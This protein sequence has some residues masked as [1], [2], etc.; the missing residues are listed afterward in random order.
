MA[1]EIINKDLGK[2]I[3]S[4]PSDPEL[5]P[6]QAAQDSLG[7]ISTDGQIE[8]CKGRLL[9][10][11]EETANGFVKGDVWGYRADGTQIHFRKVNT[12]IQYYNTTTDLWV[13]IVTGLTSSAEYSLSPYISTAGTFIY[14]TGIDGIYKI[15]T[16]NLGSYNTMYGPTDVYRGKSI[17]STGRMFMW[18]LP[19]SKSSLYGS[20][21]DGMELVTGNYTSV[22][23]EATTS[24]SGTLAFKAGD[25]KRNCFVVVITLTVSG[26]IYR[27]NLNGG[28]IGSL[29]GTGTI[30][31]I[32][33]AYTISAAGVGTASYQ[34][35]MSNSKGVTDFS[36]SATRLPLEGFILNQSEGGDFIQTVKAYDNKFYSIKNRTV[37]ELTI[38]AT[39]TTFN[40]T[41]FRRNIGL[42]YWRASVST[43]K[44]V[45]FMDTSNPE[46]PKLTI[47]QK[48]ITGDNLEPVTLADHFDFSVY[49]W[50][51]CAMNTFGEFIVFSGHTPASD[52]NNKLFFYNVRRNTV[53]ILGYEAKTIT[54]SDGLLYI[55]DTTTDNVYE[56]LSG[57]DDDNDTIE[58]YWISNDERYDTE[59]LKKVKKL[60]LKG[61]ITHDQTLQVYVSYDNNGYELV[62]TIRGDGSYVDQTESFSIGGHGIGTAIIGGEATTLLGNFYF[63]ELK[64][65]STKFRKRSIKLIASGVGYVSVTMIDDFNIR[66]F[67]QRLPSKYRSKQNVS[68]DGSQTNIGVPYVTDAYVWYNTGVLLTFDQDMTGNPFVGWNLYINGVLQALHGIS[69]WGTPTELFLI[70]FGVN[71][72][73]DDTV[74]VT[75]DEVTGDTAGTLSDLPSITLI[76]P[77]NP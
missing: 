59:A 61:L 37:Y 6:Q 12:K 29:G 24:L 4:L 7:F 45:I 39:D 31:Y 74:L 53:D 16:A 15:H 20:H 57:F 8:L 47:L 48:N 68:L 75:Y 69:S 1:K 55:G 49:E 56:I 44:G 60:R 38:D 42:D 54:S 13:D 66:R 58:N 32:T 34:W 23:G 62:G 73:I 14:A 26:E 72:T 22:T 18:D 21:K 41:V 43:G 64:V 11:A 10:G 33:G 25:A 30:N 50:D 35:E 67:E 77:R 71:I 9:L 70:V 51:M 65:D 3:V 36:Y 19:T 27:D 28:L 52:T 40:N 46:K 2:G 76:Q 63:A 5:I 17:I